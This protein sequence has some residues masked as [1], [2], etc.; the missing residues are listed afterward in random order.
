MMVLINTQSAGGVYVY[1]NGVVLHHTY[2]SGTEMH[3]L[4]WGCYLRKGDSVQFHRD[5]IYPTSVGIF[6]YG[7][8]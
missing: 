7:L 2:V 5:E 1:V 8:K 6:V 4:S 3:Q